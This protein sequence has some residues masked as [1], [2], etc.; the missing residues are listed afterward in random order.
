PLILRQ[1]RGET[2]HDRHTTAR[3]DRERAELEADT[4][5]AVKR[6]EVR[7]EAEI[8]WAEHQLT[9]ARLAIEAQA[10]IDREQQRRRVVEALEAPGDYPVQAASA[11]TFEPVEEEMYLPIA[12]EAEAA[13]KAVA[14]LP[15]S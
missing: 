5:I 9:Q 14:E 12:A 8:M 2:T 1:W 15:A 7:R 3:A 13:S 10:K 11:R 6:A 4:A